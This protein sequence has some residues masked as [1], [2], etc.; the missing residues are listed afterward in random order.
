MC[1]EKENGNFTYTAFATDSI[2]TNFSLNKNSGGIKRCYFAIITSDVE[3]NVNDNL[4]KNL[5]YNKWFNICENQDIYSIENG[6]F[7]IFK[8]F[9]NNNPNNKYILEDK[10]VACGWIKD[11]EIFLPFGQYLGGNVNDLANW[12]TSPMDFQ[13]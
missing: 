2:G 5:F 8:H 13:V 9:T 12:N 3:L 11:T 7:I 10:D 6:K 1:C 4:F